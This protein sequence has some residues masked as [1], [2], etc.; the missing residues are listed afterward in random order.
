MR[1]HYDTNNESRPSVGVV[2]PTHNRPRGL[3]Q[4]LES[5]R[6]QES[7]P[8]SV[9]IVDDGSSPAV[10]SWLDCRDPR[11]VLLR[12]D[13][14]QGPAVAR[15]QGVAAL[16]SEWVSFLDDD[17]RWLS[18]KVARCLDCVDQYPSVD[19]VFHHATTHRRGAWKR[20]IARRLDDPVR[21][22]LVTQPPHVDCILVR[23]TV[24]EDIKFNES[25]QAAADLDYMIRLAAICTV[26]ELD[27]ILAV[28]GGYDNYSSI[29]I[30]K[31]I[32]A[33]QKFH[34]EH[35]ALFAD[36]EFEATHR[37]RMGHLYRRCGQRRRAWR[38]FGSAIRIRPSH[39]RAWKGLI[40]TCYG[41]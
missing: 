17:D 12:N 38:A 20:G 1:S 16:D 23:R 18:K 26:V 21:S 13:R 27:E 6:T 41:A 40:R 28:H 22:M 39:K 32:A 25:Y 33:R 14:A 4:A 7:I 19:M 8:Q 11:L 30:E 5:V 9:V 3:L 31:R 24:H 15:N 35:R 29:S 34:E 37:T 2:I 10:S 36:P